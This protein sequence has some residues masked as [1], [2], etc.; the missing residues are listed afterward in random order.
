MKHG[1]KFSALTLAL[2]GLSSISSSQAQQAEEQAEGVER[3]AVTG[4]RIKRTDIEGPSPIQSIDATMIKGMGYENLQQLLERMPATGAGTFSTRNNSQDSTAN[5]AASVSLRGMGP[6]A[7]LVLI[8]GRR[9]AISAFAESITNSFVDINAIPVSAIERIDILKDGASAIYGSD[10]VAGVVNVILKKDYDGLEVNVG[11]GGT[12]GPSYGETTANMLWGSQSE[13]S[14][15]TVIL[16]YFNNSQLGADEMGRFG[17]ANQSPYGGMDFRSSR[18]YPGYFYV[19]GVKTIDPDCP[20]DSAT[21]SGSCLFDYGPYGLTIPASERVGFIGQFDYKISSDVTAFMEVAVQHNTSEAGGA[22][23]P[24]DEDAGLT[25]PGTHPDNPFGQDI[26]IGRYRPVDAG[27]RRWDIETDTLRFVAGLRG[28]IFDYDWEASVQKGRSS[29]EQSGDQSQGW[30]RVDWLQEQIDLGNYNPFGGVTNS[31]E[32]IDAITTSL[33]RRGESRMTSFDAHITGEAFA[34]GDEMV[35]MAAGIEYREEQVS[36]IPDIQ[37]QQGLIFGTESVSANAERDQYAAYLELSIPLSDQLELQLAGR[38][39]DYSD[40]GN[41]TNPKVALRWAPSD[42]VTLR[43]SW[44]QGFRAP[45]LAQVGLGPS[46]KSVFF[47]DR[48]RCEATGLDCESLDYNIEF[49][50]NPDLEAE[51]SESWNVGAIWAPTQELGLS[52]DIWSITQDN[53]IDE[54]QFG[55]VYDTEC[56]NQDSEICVRLDPQGSASLGVIQKIFNTYQNVSSQEAAGIDLS[57][58]YMLT[59]NDYGDVKFNL[60][61]S[62]LTEFEKDGLDYTGEYGY[63][64]HRWLFGTTWSKGAFDANLNISFVGEFEDTPDIDFDGVLDFEENTSRMVDS[65]VLVD[66]QGGYNVTDTIRLVLGVNNVLD[67]EPPFAIGDGD[68]DLYGYVGSIH[69]P[70]GRFVYTKATFR[71]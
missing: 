13:K 3:I 9:V 28:Q 22:A 16:D 38:Y 56:N 29:S 63:P 23:T 48:Y 43:A 7:T 39:D 53:K 52:V 64:E 69:N 12:T 35:M 8:N 4:S 5:G 54:Q 62:Y 21:A 26:D 71:F 32:V 34:L 1:V 25:V 59:L 65:Q 50:G 27:A 30:V 67:E 36:D 17:T 68:S 46:Q 24:L 31:P 6:D 41:T 15:A 47:V 10:A 51:E 55:L 66:I 49:A 11:Y 61:W 14:S 37:F 44:A 20:A 33:V 19:D 60:D 42:E 58:N 45:S 70:R 57:A 40:F 2:A 18:G